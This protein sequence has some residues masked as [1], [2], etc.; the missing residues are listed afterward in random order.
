[1]NTVSSC[2]TFL[3]NTLDEKHRTIMPCLWIRKSWTGKKIQWVLPPRPLPHPH[4]QVNLIKLKLKSKANKTSL[5]Q[6]KYKLFTKVQNLT[7][8]AQNWVD[9]SW[10]HILWGKKTVLFVDWICNRTQSC[11]VSTKKQLQSLVTFSVPQKTGD[12]LPMVLHTSWPHVEYHIDLR[13]M[14]LKSNPSLTSQVFKYL[15][16]DSKLPFP[17]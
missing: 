14:H 8:H 16:T 1:M 2:P 15:K 17:S 9:L 7:F 13:G 3:F 12:Y 4:T 11:D 6:E 10:K 5:N